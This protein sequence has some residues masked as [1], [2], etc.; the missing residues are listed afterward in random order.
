MAPWEEEEDAMREF[1]CLLQD[2]GEKEGDVR[3][4][5]FVGCKSGERKRALGEKGAFVGLQTGIFMASGTHQ[6]LLRKL[7]KL[8][9]I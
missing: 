6:P 9:Q 2:W 8:I 7:L 1:F 3:E 5:N 4:W